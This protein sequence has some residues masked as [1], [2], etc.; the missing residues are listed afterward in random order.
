M[1]AAAIVAFSCKRILTWLAERPADGFRLYREPDRTMKIQRHALPLV[2]VLSLLTDRAVAFA[3]GDI[4][5]AAPKGGEQIVCD[6]T[7]VRNK[8]EAAPAVQRNLI[9]DQIVR[10]TDVACV[11]GAITESRNETSPSAA[12][13]V[14]GYAGNKE[15]SEVSSSDAGRASKATPTTAAFPVVQSETHGNAPHTGWPLNYWAYLAFGLAVAWRVTKFVLG[16]SGARR[17][18][19]GGISAQG[20]EIEAGSKPS[21]GES[22]SDRWKRRRREGLI[23]TYRGVP[24]KGGLL[25][26]QMWPGFDADV[27]YDGDPLREFE[28]RGTQTVY[29]TNGNAQIFFGPNSEPEKYDFVGDIID[30]YRL[31]KQ[32]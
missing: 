21:G 7:L 9:H 20:T 6:Y 17:G 32:P 22:E 25:P 5:C 14:S 3:V 28:W 1:E 19:G 11:D 4:D 26:K 23:E 12:A 8:Y 29:K 24:V 27:Y 15:R 18:T 13:E 10:C 31:P 2:F 30:V 16:L